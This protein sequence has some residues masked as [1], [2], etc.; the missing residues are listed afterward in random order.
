MS[1][2]T[3]AKK[4]LAPKTPPSAE[5]TEGRQKIEKAEEKFSSDLAI[6]IEL[7]PLMTEKGMKAQA[8]AQTAVF[9]VWRGASKR[10]IARAVEEQYKVKPLAIR[11]VNVRGKI[12]RRGAV[13]GVTSAWKK[14]YV[15][16]EDVQKLHG[17][18]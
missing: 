7:M 11:T 15:K 17:A 12:R 18:P 3:R 2:L 1:L 4:L 14:A 8:Q 9:S 10:D 16:V 6:R 5:A 13:E